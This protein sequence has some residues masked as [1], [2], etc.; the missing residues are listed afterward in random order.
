MQAQCLGDKPGLSCLAIR[1]NRHNHSLFDVLRKWT[2]P[3]FVL[4]RNDIDRAADIDFAKRPIRSRLLGFSRPD[5][6]T[7]FLRPI[8][9]HSLPP[10][11]LPFFLGRRY[12]MGPDRFNRGRAHRVNGFIYHDR[13]RSLCTNQRKLDLRHGQ[14]SSLRSSLQSLDGNPVMEWKTARKK[15]KR[16]SA[17]RWY[18]IAK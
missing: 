17:Y 3:R 7:D 11:P 14:V 16:N 13:P 4:P 6:R 18:R 5:E 9:L 2:R 12:T 15:E 8:L 1:R 10:P